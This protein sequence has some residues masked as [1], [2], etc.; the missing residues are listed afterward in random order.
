MRTSRTSMKSNPR[1]PQLEKAHTQQQR[2]STAEHK[3]ILKTKCCSHQLL[4]RLQCA[5]ITASD[6]VCDQPLPYSARKCRARPL[7][8][9]GLW[10]A[11][12]LDSEALRPLDP[13]P[14]P[15]AGSSLTRLT[16]PRNLRF[17]AQAVHST[18]AQLW[19][20]ERS[21]SQQAEIFS[22]GPEDACYLQAP[23]AWPPIS[24]QRP[25]R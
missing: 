3:I 13:S 9:P 23:E 18:Q 5:K 2:L 10:E 15:L 24:E 7:Q 1:Y 12:P 6:S 20:H 22:V 11:Q 14:K 19:H 17:Q 21:S 8:S 16:R 25:K 4:D